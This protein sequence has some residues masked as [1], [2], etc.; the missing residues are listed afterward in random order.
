[1]IVFISS[2]CSCDFYVFFEL[3]SLDFR[4]RLAPSILR[5]LGL[6]LLV[7]IMDRCLVRLCA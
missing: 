7:G 2:C 4:V 5:F 3:F 1:M 6:Y